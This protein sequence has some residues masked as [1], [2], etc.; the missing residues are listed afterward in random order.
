[1]RNL[2]A[3][4]LDFALILAGGSKVVGK[5]HA[6]PSFWRAAKRLGQADGHNRT[7]AGL[8]VDNIVESLEGDPETFCFFSNGQP[9]GFKACAPHDAS[10]MGRIFHG[11]GYLSLFEAPNHRELRK[12]A[13]TLPLG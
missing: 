9:Q 3:S 13:D 12:L 7:N 10:G 5:L 2:L 11:H 6:Q 4:R 8:A 1:L